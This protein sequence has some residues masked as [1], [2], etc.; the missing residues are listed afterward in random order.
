MKFKKA[1]LMGWIGMIEF[2]LAL[3]GLYMVYA[4]Y[5]KPLFS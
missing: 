4:H 5:I 2:V 3:F 1:L